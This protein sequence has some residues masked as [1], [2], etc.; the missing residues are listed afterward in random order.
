MGYVIKNLPSYE[1]T[2]QATESQQTAQKFREVDEKLQKE[3][4]ARTTADLN[5]QGAL[6]ATNSTLDDEIALRNSETSQLRADL[7][8][9]TNQ[10]TSTDENLQRQIDAEVLE[11]QAEESA[12]RDTLNSKIDTEKHERAAAIDDAVK[13]IQAAMG[14]AKALQAIENENLREKISQAAET[15]AANFQTLNEKIESETKNRTDEDSKLTGALADEIKNRKDS[16]SALKTEFSSDLNSEIAARETADTELKT[17]LE[18]KIAAET[19]NRNAAVQTLETSLKNYANEKFDSVSESLNDFTAP[20]NSADGERGLVPAPPKGMLSGILTARGWRTPQEASLTISTVP[21]QVGTL[22]YNRNNQSPTWINFDNTKLKITGTT[23]STDAGTFIAEFTPIDLYMWADTLN[24]E[25]RQV[26][27]KMEPLRLAKPAA[28]VTTFT[29]NNNSQGISVSNYDSTY[30]TQGGTTSATNAADYSATYTLKNTNNTVWSDNS[31]GRVTIS[32]KIEPLKLTKPSASVKNFDYDGNSHTLSVSNYNSTY[33]N[34]TGTVSAT[35]VGTYSVKFTLKSTANTTWT[36]GTTSAV[37]ISWSIEQTEL[38]EEQSKGFAQSGSLTYDGNSQSPVINNYNA[39]LHQ[40]SGDTEAINAGTYT[41]YVSPKS[42]GTWYDGTD[43]PKP[44]TWKIDKL[45]L[46][47]PTAA[48]TVFP[49]NGSTYSLEISNYNSAYMTMTGT[50]SESATGSYKV[51]FSLNSTNIMWADKKT[52]DVVINWTIGT[53]VLAKPTAASTTFEYTGEEKSL[54]VQN[55]DASYMN[56]EGTLSAINAGSYSVKFILKDK[57]NTKWSGNSTADITISWKIN[58]KKLTAAESTISIASNAQTTFTYGVAHQF[59]NEVTR[60]YDGLALIT[61]Y[62]STIHKISD[63]SVCAAADAGTYTIKITPQDNYTWSNGSV[64]A[65]SFTWK[66]NKLLLKK[67]TAAM[68]TWTYDGTA[69]YIKEAW[70]DGNGGYTY[71]VLTGYSRLGQVTSAIILS[72]E[73][74]ENVDPDDITFGKDKYAFAM[75]T[76]LK[77]A[78]S[79]D[80]T[81]SLNPDFAGNIAWV[82]NSTADIKITVKINRKKLSANQSTFK[83]RNE[84][85]DTWSNS[86]FAEGDPKSFLSQIVNGDGGEVQYLVSK[87]AGFRIRGIA[88]DS[89]RSCYFSGDIDGTDAGSYT[90]YA[91]PAANFCWSD[92]SV[93][94]KTITAYIL[95]RVT[96]LPVPSTVPPVFAYDARGEKK[97][98][99]DEQPYNRGLGKSG[100][101]R[102]T[103]IG[104]YTYNFILQYYPNEIWN[105]SSVPSYISVN[106]ATAAVNWSITAT[107]VQTPSLSSTKFTFDGNVKTVTLNNLDSDLVSVSGITSGVNAADYS[108][109]LSLKNAG[110]TCWE[111]NTTDDKVLTWTITRKPLTATQS[112]FSQNGTLT[113]NGSTQTVTIKNFDANYH[114]LGGVYTS[115]NAGSFIAQI[116]PLDNFCWNDGTTSTKFVTWTINPIKLTKPTA[117]VTSF[118]YDKEAHAL[119]LSNVN[120]TYMNQTGSTS[121]IEPGNYSATFSLKNTTNTVWADSSTASVVIAWSITKKLLPL[122]YI[123]SQSE[124]T[125]DGQTK[126]VTV[127]NFDSKYMSMDGTTSLIDAG[128]RN[129][130]FTLTDDTVDFENTS[131]RSVTL[132]WRVTPAKLS[133]AQSAPSAKTATFTGKTIQLSTL[134]QNYNSA[135]CYLNGTTEAVN[136]GTYSAQVYL[137]GNYTW[138]DGTTTAKEISWTIAPA[139]LTAP[140]VSGDLTYNQSVQSPTLSGFDSSKMTLG[141]VTSATNAGEYSLT[142]TPAEN[143]IWDS[144]D[145]EPVSYTWSIAKIKVT[146]PTW[147]KAT[148]SPSFNT[149]TFTPEFNNFDE[150]IMSIGGDTSALHAGNYSAVFKL[151]DAANYCWDG[152][153]G[154]NVSVNWKINK[155][156]IRI[157]VKESPCYLYTGS[158]IQYSIRVYNAYMDDTYIAPDTDQKTSAWLSWSGTIEAVAI[159]NYSVS[160]TNKYPEDTV[161]DFMN[162]EYVINHNLP[163]YLSYSRPRVYAY[164]APTLT[165]GWS[166][167]VTSVTAP[168]LEKTYLEYTG[169]LQTVSI[170]NFDSSKM[171]KSGDESKTAR[172]FYK[173]TFALKDKTNTCWSTGGSDDIVIE[174]ALGKTRVTKPTLSGDTVFVYNGSSKTLSVT[175][176]DSN[177]MTQTGYLSATDAGSYSVVYSLKNTTEYIWDDDSTA[178]VT[179]SWKIEKAALPA[180]TF[181]QNGTLTYDGSNKTVTIKNYDAKLHDLS[182]TITS[183]EA[184]TFTAKITPKA[185]YTW[186]DGTSTAKNITWKI[187]AKAITRPTVSPLNFEYDG[188]AHAL[189][190]TNYSTS[191]MTW[192]GTTSATEVGEYSVTFR[193]KNKTSNYWEGG[194]NDNITYNWSIGSSSIAIP[195]V[196][197]TSQVSQGLNKSL[198]FTLSGYDSAKM[199]ATLSSASRLTMSGST[200]TV[201]SGEA[202]N[203]SIKFTLKDSTN[204]AFSNGAA[205]ANVTFSVTKKVLTAAES[206]FAQTVAVPYDGNEHSVTEAV[207]AIKSAYVGEFYTLTNEKGTNGTIKTTITPT[208]AACW[209]D[210]TSSAKTVEWEIEAAIPTL[211]LASD[212]VK[213]NLSYGVQAESL[214]SPSHIVTF[215]TNSS[216]DITVQTSDELV[217]AVNVKG[218]SRTSRTISASAG[219][220]YVYPR[221][222]GTCTI[223]VT[224][225][226]SGG[227]KE[228][229]KYLTVTVTAAG[230]LLSWSEIQTLAKTGN[231]LNYMRIGDR[232]AKIGL[233]GTVGTLSL[234]GNFQFMLI[235]YNHNSGVE[236]SNRA[237]FMLNTPDNS[238][239]VLVDSNY[240]KQAD[241]GFIYS[242][243]TIAYNG[244]ALRTCCTEF[245]NALPTELQNVI[246][247]CTK[248]NSGAVSTSDKVWIPSHYEFCGGGTASEQYEYFANG[249]SRAFGKNYWTRCLDSSHHSPYYINTSGAA[250]AVGTGYENYSYGFLPCFTV[251]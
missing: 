195:T 152:A 168:S 177:K 191:T 140:T 97:L 160:I 86:Q 12:L 29:F 104:N 13:A 4:E 141:N 57:T 96:E 65:K 67:P 155:A 222:N 165:F 171:T 233:E 22:T 14:D 15:Q 18:T 83:L 180:V 76:E 66:I 40:L 186:S 68:F 53:L 129:L 212:T 95:Q 62:D 60:A 221:A 115:T 103:D 126:S 27:W 114:K 213:L 179:F 39:K 73:F 105:T 159:G 35:E 156:I 151:K 216:G 244:S 81:F 55:Y 61:G 48:T 3:T 200:V 102:A 44:V 240:G 77:T 210:G 70:S 157:T 154:D 209:N 182:G 134:M 190:L 232:T 5:L 218:Y 204:T 124:F 101:W 176:Y 54:D 139:T 193:L 175:G 125:Y 90:F 188:K 143:Y 85:W 130:I 88:V 91:E 166:I 116:S 32:W 47:K 158:K 162:S 187:F 167:G 201:K 2:R 110:A 208:A 59:R 37:T 217:A 100:T 92:G 107:Q 206:T 56:T 28:S 20:T 24:Q 132:H 198:T 7:L 123:S 94:K 181:T 223:S 239:K 36:N 227:F 231:L 45:T 71:E 133:A 79:G 87:Y 26:T 112:T 46:E 120:S 33:M 25:T 43:D 31:T 207:T 113:Y 50:T 131:E 249:N 75:D 230:V 78:G 84:S 236:G 150:N 19:T 121:A 229:T 148:S 178:D 226:A 6:D 23:S 108:V 211:K 189:T 192:L 106:G 117:A 172:G 203:Y 183:T 11:R 163:Y 51:T 99:F 58:K 38:T 118:T 234:S 228:V 173:I 220:F 64:T 219:Q 225:K 135:A 17:S 246:Q 8:T 245:Y 238:D 242:R 49:Y 136:A 30:I 215:T 128:G 202:Q 149:Q 98:T 170:K 74:A 109:T 145:S 161:W 251:G 153:A 69:H 147:T 248:T 205:T 93:S 214:S 243:A 174:W 9:E 224:Q 72:G 42:G 41:L 194:G 164:N 16:D 82:G 184:G 146:V 137:T 237:H 142:I 80:C 34:R 1:Q 197:P 127:K 169:N 196:S 63:D 185:N 89:E 21:S 122:P 138:A 247:A 235:G 119:N 250:V 10:R 241:S 111:D 52:A 144:G 199:T